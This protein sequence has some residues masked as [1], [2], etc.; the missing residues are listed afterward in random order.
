M[1]SSV[2][3][4]NSCQEDQKNTI[5]AKMHGKRSG[6]GFCRVQKDCTKVLEFKKLNFTTR[7]HHVWL[8]GESG[9]VIACHKRRLLGV[10]SSSLLDEVHWTDGRTVWRA[11][12]RNGC[13]DDAPSPAGA[14]VTTQLRRRS[15]FFLLPNSR[16]WRHSA[17]TIWTYAAAYIQHHTVG[18]QNN[19]TL[20]DYEELPLFWVARPFW[21]SAAPCS[22]TTSIWLN[23]LSEKSDIIA[24][25]KFKK[26]LGRKGHVITSTAWYDCATSVVCRTTVHYDWLAASLPCVVVKNWSH[27]SPRRKIGEQL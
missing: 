13:H 4:V 14:R 24:Y 17:R 9:C 18:R 27:L 22:N 26:S 19:S 6:P 2:R 7:I 21:R 3:L 11:W 5:K 20:V 15:L 8:I 1:Y 16:S 10:S 23:N 25:M 12:W